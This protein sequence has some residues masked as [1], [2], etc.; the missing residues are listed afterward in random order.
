VVCFGG[1]I[2][3]P[4][5]QS[6]KLS[7]SDAFQVGSE[8]LHMGLLHSCAAILEAGRPMTPW[9]D[10]VERRMVLVQSELE[11]RHLTVRFFLIRDLLTNHIAGQDMGTSFPRGAFAAA[12]RHRYKL[13]NP[14]GCQK[15]HYPTVTVSYK[16]TC[17]QPL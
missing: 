12:G 13:R 14:N 9:H 2:W 4:R 15:C 1:A 3:D 5:Q 8:L 10:C 7:L 6:D 11:F 17:P 16:L